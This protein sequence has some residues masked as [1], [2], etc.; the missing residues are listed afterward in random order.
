M[1]RTSGTDPR[2]TKTK[3]PADRRKMEGVMEAS[4]EKLDGFLLFVGGTYS[5]QDWLSVW[6]LNR[7]E[8]RA[9]ISF[10]W[11]K[12]RRKNRNRFN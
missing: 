3:V 11:G 2:N 7:G 6:A 1:Q 12:W 8:R 10:I 9:E 4:N 5:A